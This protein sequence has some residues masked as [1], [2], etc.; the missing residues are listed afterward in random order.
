M[1]NRELKQFA[2]KLSKALDD[3]SW[4]TIDPELIAEIAY[5]PKRVWSGGAASLAECLKEALK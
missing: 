5:K 4:G 3:D 2:M 1:T